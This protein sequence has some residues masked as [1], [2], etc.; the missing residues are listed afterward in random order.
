MAATVNVALWPEK[1][2]V[3]AGGMVME[4]G[5]QTVTVPVFTTTAPPA[6]TVS[7]HVFVP[8]VA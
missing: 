7:F 2:E 1:M 5:V 3:L 4:G 6:V 8:A